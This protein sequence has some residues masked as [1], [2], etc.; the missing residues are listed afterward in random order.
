[1]A[2]EANEA[3]KAVPEVRRSGVT[4]LIGDAR[5]VENLQALRVATARC[6]VVTTDDDLG[7]LEIALTARSLNPEIKIVM[8]LHDPDLAVRVQRGIG[9]GVSR[10][11]AGL[12][13]PA[14]V[15]AAIGHQVVTTLPVGD[16]TLVLARTAIAAGSKADGRTIGWLE[17]G[18]YARV[19]KVDHGEEALWKPDREV[20]L[21]AGDQLL[22]VAT[23][24]GLDGVL[25]RTER[26]AE[27]VTA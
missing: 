4:V 16:R 17:D 11:T 25:R 18:P 24:K 14:F 1:M 13:A 19:V 26:T 22:L 15:S 2:M 9:V 8:E 12:A 21:T 10:S 23:R 20:T 5:E 6:L 3:A 27:P 7:N